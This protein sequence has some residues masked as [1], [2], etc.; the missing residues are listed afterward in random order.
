[1][2]TVVAGRRGGYSGDRGRLLSSDVDAATGGGVS[3]M[4]TRYL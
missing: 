2:V 4:V 1:M 3:T